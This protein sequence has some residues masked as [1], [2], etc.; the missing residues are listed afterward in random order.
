MHCAPPLTL[1]RPLAQ[2]EHEP[3]ISHEVMLLALPEPLQLKD[4]L[5]CQNDTAS[6]SP[7]LLRRRGVGKF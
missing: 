6:Q 4:A 7:V 1:T 2:D 5:V 3:R